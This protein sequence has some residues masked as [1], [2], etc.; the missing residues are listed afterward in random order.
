V[1]RPVREA[2]PSGPAGEVSALGTLEQ[3][4]RRIGL[5]AL[6]P[7][8]LVLLLILAYPIVDSMLLSLASVN[9]AGTGF[10]RHFIGIDNYLALAGDRV[11]RQAL[12]SSVYFTLLEVVLVI[13]LAL[14]VAL[15]L[16]HPFGRA[17][18]FRIVLIVPWAIAPVANAVLWKWILHANYGILNSVLLQLGII[19]RNIVWLGTGSRALHVLLLVDVWKSVPFIAILFLAGLSKIPTILYRAARLDGAN[20]WQQFWHVTLP[21]LRPTIAV[22]VILQ[23]LWALRIFDLIYV[24]TKGGPAGGTVLLNYLAYRTTFNDLD[25]GYGAAIAN[26]IFAMSFALALAYVWLLKPGLQQAR[27]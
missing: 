20:A 16:V 22:A 26:V 27:A 13:V 1:Q 15:L 21:S 3:R 12:W 18:F 10:A 4:R 24:L 9:V 25:L 19:E 14:L 17:G 11:F 8:L 2:G 23:T 5:A 7:T 6:A